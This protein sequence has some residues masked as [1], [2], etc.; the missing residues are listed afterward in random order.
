M[1]EWAPIAKA[2]QRAASEAGSSIG[3][4]ELRIGPSVDPS[5]ARQAYSASAA[6]TNLEAAR[7][8]LRRVEDLLACLDCAEQYRGG[9]LQRCPSCG[10]DGLVVSPAPDAQLIL[11]PDASALAAAVLEEFR[12]IHDRVFLGDPAANPNLEVEVLGATSVGAT[13]AMVLITPWTCN[14]LVFPADRTFPEKVSVGDAVV[15][16]RPIDLA[17]SIGRFWSANLIAN[18]S[19]FSDQSAARRAA[20]A[21]VPR[22]VQA[23]ESFCPPLAV[24]EPE[25]EVEGGPA[26]QMGA[27]SRRQLL[28]AWR[29]TGGDH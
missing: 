14:G 22:W 4:V 9:R 8:E 10:G 21:W 2:V 1:H 29:T 24:S 3:P 17:G 23:V 20:A 19:R 7:M 6:G 11:G 18:V 28:S 25:D 16:S 27:L 13:A 5:V 12:D 15:A 26:P